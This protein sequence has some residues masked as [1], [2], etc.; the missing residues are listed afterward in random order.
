MLWVNTTAPVILLELA[1]V[2]LLSIGGWLGGTLVNRNFIGP[3]HRY[4]HAGKWKEKSFSDLQPEYEAAATD[5]LK[6]NQMKLIRIKD[7][8]IVLARTEEGYVSFD[9]SCTHRGGSLA[10]GVLICGTVQCLW[11]GSQFNTSTGAVAAGPAQKNIKTYT[12]TER[13]GKIFITI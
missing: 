5:E 3:D 11:H 6:V 1:A 9:D 2:I 13:N 8:R 10:D 12:V 7:K 4:A